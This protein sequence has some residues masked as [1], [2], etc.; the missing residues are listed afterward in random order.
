[1]ME[2]RKTETWEEG[3]L[4][5]YTGD[6]K[7]KT[8]AALGLILRAAGRGLPCFLGQ[9]MKG[10]G[11]GELRALE[12]FA[13]LVRVEQ[14]GS[15]E[16]IPWREE[17]AEEDLALAAAGL[18]RCREVLEAGEHKI[19]VLD[20]ISVTV[21]FRLITEDQLM[22]LVA[23]RPAHVELV[24]T[25]RYAPKRLIEAADLVTEMREVKH[26]YASKGAPARDGIER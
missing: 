9:F 1:M 13:G 7:G 21:R 3:G 16:C 6:G 11:Y 23:A 10:Y 15:P 4:Q 22:D 20:E 24:C 26:P 2:L 18:D 5:V 8:T 17:P 19:V 25:G 12:A 14:F